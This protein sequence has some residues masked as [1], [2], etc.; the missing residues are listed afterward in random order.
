MRD[1]WVLYAAYAAFIFI[2]W[3]AL[4]PPHKSPIRVESAQS[5]SAPPELRLI[6]ERSPH[7]RNER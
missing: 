4:V 7:M 6:T 3:L 2:A 1:H 5:L